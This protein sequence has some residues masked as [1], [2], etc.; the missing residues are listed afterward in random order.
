M[1]SGRRNWKWMVPGLFVPVLFVLTIWMN[2]WAVRAGQPWLLWCGCVSVPGMA[3]LAVQA[4]AGFRAYYQ[5]LE[6]D[7]LERRRNALATT[8]EIRLFEAARGMHPEAVRLL[9]L[10]KKDVWR[11]KETPVNELVDWVLDADPRVHVGFVEYVLENSMA[12]AIMPKHGRL[13]DKAYSF[14]PARLVTDYEQ[15]DAFIR[16]CQT[17]GLLTEAFGNQPGRWIEPW[18]PELVARRFGVTLE[19]DGQDEPA[20]ENPYIQKGAV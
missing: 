6:T 5:S 13:S 7:Q 15:Y 14:D 18:T 2:D 4:V 3:I 11:I 19:E 9:L 8:A 1:Y 12:W 16:L 17:R 10:H 20:V